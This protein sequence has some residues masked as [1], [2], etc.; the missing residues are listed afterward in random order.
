MTI[1]FLT[2]FLLFGFYSCGQSGIKH[3]VDPEAVQ[4]NNRAMML[5]AFMDNPDSSRKAISLLDEATVID[6][7]YFLGFYNK[8]MFYNQLKQFDKAILTINKLIQLRPKA[9]DLYL[10]GG[11][12]YELLGDTISSKAYFEKSLAICT[13][14]LD[15]LSRKNNNYEMLAG[16]AAINLIMLGDQARANELLKKLNDGQ[17]NDARRKWIES[18]M[19]KN[20]VEL[21][22]LLTRDN[23][24]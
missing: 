7:S 15:T 5:V 16:N 19:N 13:D 24:D 12:Y 21:L 22:E 20:K 18:L 3:K 10:S 11:I 4:L 23:Q 8:L 14:V 1:K 9:H 2:A 17:T 6:S